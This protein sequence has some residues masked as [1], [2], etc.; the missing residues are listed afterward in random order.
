MHTHSVVDQVSEYA[1]SVDCSSGDKLWLSA[2][3]FYKGAL[4]RKE[5]LTKQLVMS[6]T[7]TGELVADS[8]SLRNEFFEDALKETNQR[9]FDGED[10]NCIPKK[11]Y[12]LKVN[13]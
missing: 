7:E 10:D 5:K 2:M 1:L 8:G 9:L 3:A 4:V 13:F 12:T 11:D 6:F